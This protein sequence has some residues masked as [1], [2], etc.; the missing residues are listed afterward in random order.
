MVPDQDPA[1]Q[2]DSCKW[3]YLGAIEEPSD[4]ELRLRILEAVTGG[5]VSDQALPFEVTS[6]IRET[7]RGLREISHLSG[8]R[9]F[10][11]F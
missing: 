4:N 2:F 6:G 1:T 9:I 11:V 3:L 5:T 10:D 8:C 7:L